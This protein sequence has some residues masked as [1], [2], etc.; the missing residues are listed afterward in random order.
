[1]NTEKR[2][3]KASILAGATDVLAGLALYF[4]G[5]GDWYYAKFHVFGIIGFGMLAYGYWHLYFL[6]KETGRG[7]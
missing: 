7:V 2:I 1:M 6:R 3:I 4:T 5:A